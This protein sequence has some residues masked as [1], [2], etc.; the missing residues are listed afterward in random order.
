MGQKTGRGCKLTGPLG[1]ERVENIG[2]VP[3]HPRPEVRVEVL[4]VLCALY[5]GRLFLD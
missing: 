3:A 1:T 5:T 4:A 2:V